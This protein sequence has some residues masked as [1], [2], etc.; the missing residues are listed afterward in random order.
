MLSLKE[1]TTNASLMGSVSRDVLIDKH[2]QR[3][4]QTSKAILIYVL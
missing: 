1:L 3:D 4:R 2:A